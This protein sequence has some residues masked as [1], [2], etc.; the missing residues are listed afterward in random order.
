MDRFLKFVNQLLIHKNILYHTSQ[1]V[2]SPLQ[3]VTLSLLYGLLTSVQIKQ[4]FRSVVV[5]SLKLFCCINTTFFR[6]T[7]KTDWLSVCNHYSYF[8]V[9]RMP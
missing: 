5:V 6:A 4:Y 9:L 3:Y 1:R 7:Q 8:V 2:P